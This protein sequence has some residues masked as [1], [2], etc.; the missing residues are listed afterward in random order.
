ML[1]ILKVATTVSRNE[2]ENFGS[3]KSVEGTTH[4]HGV[5]K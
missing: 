3:S 5:L 1:P 2:E 4:S